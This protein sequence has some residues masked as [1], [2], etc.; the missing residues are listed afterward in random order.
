MNKDRQ[1]THGVVM[2]EADYFPDNPT[3]APKDF[4]WRFRMNKEL[5]MKIVI[6]VRKYYNY[7]MRKKYCIKFSGLT[8]VINARLP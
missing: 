3:H 4:R 7:C 8:L 2:L 5:S 1:W 6:G